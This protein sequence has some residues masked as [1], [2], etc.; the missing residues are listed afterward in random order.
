[1]NAN[2]M[3]TN[4]G[5]LL[6]AVLA[7]FIIVAG[8][9]VIFSDSVQAA[10]GDESNHYTLESVGTVQVSDSEGNAVEG[11]PMSL[12][13]A[14]EQ[15]KDN[16][17]WTLKAGYYNVT[18]KSTADFIKDQNVS[19]FN[20]TA[21][22]ITIQGEEGAEVILFSDYA[23]SSYQ[24]P[25]VDA[26]Q[27]TTV[28]IL[29][30]GVTLKN[31]TVANMYT[32]TDSQFEAYKS[33]E[34][35]GADAKLSDVEIVANT[36]GQSSSDK[37]EVSVDKTTYGGVLIVS[38]EGDHGTLTLEDVTINNGVMNFTWMS[39]GNVDVIA[40]NVVMN[41]TDENG[42]GI[43]AT[44]AD[45][46]FSVLGG[47]LTFNLNSEDAH[48]TSVINQAPAGSTVNVN[49]NVTLT[50]ETTIKS[51]VNVN[52][53]SGKTVSSTSNVTLEGRLSGAGSISVTGEGTLEIVP[54]S[55]Y[56]ANNI[57]E[58]SNV[59]GEST[60]KDVFLSGELISNID[61]TI[62][63]RII[64]TDD[65]VV[66]EGLHIY[67]AGQFIVEEG[68]TVTFQTGS[69]VVFRDG[70]TATI[71]GDITVQSGKTT[72]TLQIES[73]ATVD[74]NGSVTLEGADSFSAD[75]SAEI[76][77]NG[78]FEI[79]E[80][81][82]ATLGNATI[83]SGAQLYVYGL[84]SGTVLNNG[85]VTIDS[86]GISG[87]SP[88]N[89]NGFN[90][91][92]GAGATVDVKNIY[93][94]VNISDSDL[95]C[96]IN[97][98]DVDVKN[99]NSI[100]LRHVSGVT[101]TETL[102][103]KNDDDGN[104]YG[105]NTMLVSGSI[106]DG[107]MFD[108]AS[109]TQNSTVQV[110]GSNIAIAEDTTFT[111]VDLTVAGGILNVSAQVVFGGET[112][113]NTAATITGN[114]VINV[115]GKITSEYEIRDSPVVNGVVYESGTGSDK[116]YVY[117]TLETAL[118]DGAT[119][120][121]AT[122]TFTVEESVTIP[123]G[124]TVD[125]TAA[126]ITIAEDATVTVAAQD[127]S[128]G[129][130]TNQATEGITVD[131]TL[132]VENLDRS[133]V[134]ESGI[135]SDTSSKSGGSATYT[136]IY[137]ALENAQ[138]GET[139]EITKNGN[140]AGTV[141]LDRDVEVKSG[142]T[143]EIPSTKTLVVDNDVVLTVNGTVFING[144]TLTINGDEVTADVEDDAGSVV[145]NGML[146]SISST[147]GFKEDIAGAYFGYNNLNVIAPLDTAAGLIND[148]QTSEIQ[149]YLQNEVSDITF[150]YAG[151]DVITLVNNG[152]LVAGNIDLGTV[153]FQ[154]A[155]N[156]STTATLVLTNGTVGLD[157][158]NGITVRDVV[159]YD[160]NNNAVYTATIS[161]DSVAA[162]DNKDTDDVVESGT[163]TIS[164][165]VSS[166]ATYNGTENA[167]TGTGVVD[168]IVTSDSTL[169]TTGGKIANV[170][171][172][173]T[174]TATGTTEVS[175]ASVTG[176]ISVDKA[177]LSIGTLYA[178][179]T[180]EEKVINENATR[181]VLTVG[182]GTAVIGDGVTVTGTAYVAPGTTLGESITSTDNITEYYVND[183]L[184]VTA[185][186]KANTGI[187]AIEAP[188]EHAEFVSWQYD[189]N[190]T[191]SDVESGMKIGDYDKVYANIN[192]D[193]YSIDVSAC[194]GVSIYI[195][196][197]E[198]NSETL[199]SY[200][201]H[202]I[203]VYV[204]PNYEGTPEITVNGQAVTSGTFELTGDTEIT[205]T[206]VTASSG[207]IVIDNGGD[208]DSLG[209]TDYLL[210]VLVILIVIMAIIVAMRLMRS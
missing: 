202:N 51:G 203:T 60:Y 55:S 77:I 184:F 209:L 36:W 27:G 130:L 182:E 139:V 73:G 176:T 162:L 70:S 3:K 53:A 52:I 177:R 133:G 146:T 6:T 194:P 16:Q 142:V 208:S 148:I 66:G 165:E 189:K 118:A 91:Q 11:S 207:Q 84:V 127:K 145:V 82:S 95:K 47:G 106:T 89:I 160:E 144:G 99:N 33:V 37:S 29:G 38:G 57:S 5:K 152:T 18:G 26:N 105:D 32:Y 135:V 14:L 116:V 92:M 30:N 50:A 131:G 172:A 10:E 201:Q 102:E 28:A 87:A 124:T 46:D 83:A 64:V 35:L 54:G 200:G 132:V 78:I 41:V 136:N 195:D 7:M 204:S 45:V 98:V 40:D 81:A 117:T 147:D 143:L 158:V 196:G 155:A 115:T 107:A 100:M 114:G 22:N 169:T 109:K 178:G 12:G 97:G 111:D 199:Y 65:L 164:G 67:V 19:K 185:Y 21:N 56:N 170:T 110:N 123:V 197:K 159:T 34:I 69:S 8:A 206:G 61:G 85:T 151:D 24:S 15:Q 74:V 173:G 161:G 101:V 119:K 68:A 140:E 80:D 129:K 126:K 149:L 120:I 23:D 71:N 141:T 90:I 137:N 205:V 108:G 9:T 154:S 193:I 93:G 125:A 138:D 20:I 13:D 168:V 25:D 183:E 44:D 104:R 187:S 43:N 58:D 113:D 153:T 48:A 42:Y 31:L 103:M 192:Y 171:V 122:G 17:T 39:G 156:S 59:T 72:S 198:W 134:T 166:S 121:T 188:A 79:G 191:L 179:V 2:V 175:I 190:G 63:Q 210:I 96:R 180:A 1:M 157:N 4:T 94:F 86:E 76:N 128:S 49:E 163:V 62:N 167:N 181:Y 186:D 112:A 75:N 150:D 88:A 174:L